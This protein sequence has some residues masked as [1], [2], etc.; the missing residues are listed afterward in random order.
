MGDGAI[1]AL[2]R[3]KRGGLVLRGAKRLSHQLC[4]RHL[5]GRI[6]IAADN[7]GDAIL[8]RLDPGQQLLDQTFRPSHQTAYAVD[9]ITELG[10]KNGKYSS[11][12]VSIT[13]LSRKQ[14]DDIYEGLHARPEIVMTF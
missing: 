2:Q 11:V 10:S 14:L 13:A 7:G 8:A 12:T 3:G 6:K 1:V 4:G 9:S 5:Q